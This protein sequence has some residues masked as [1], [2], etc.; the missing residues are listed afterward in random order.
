MIYNGLDF[1]ILI[2]DSNYLPALY[3]DLQKR[4][5][6]PIIDEH[7]SHCMTQEMTS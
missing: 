1:D 4:T 2:L 5:F 3:T 6:Q 7:V